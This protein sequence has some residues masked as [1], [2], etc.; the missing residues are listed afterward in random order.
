MNSKIIT[1]ALL[2][3]SHAQYPTNWPL[4]SGLELMDDEN[5][6]PSANR[7]NGY[8]CIRTGNV[9]YFPQLKGPGQTLSTSNTC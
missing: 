4:Y 9:W 8:A 5:R 7:M 2:G 3:V 1:M 6:I